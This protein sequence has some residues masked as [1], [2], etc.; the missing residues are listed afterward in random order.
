MS[1][2]MLPPYLFHFKEIWRLYWQFFETIS[3]YLRFPSKTVVIE[4]LARCL[5]QQDAVEE[6]NGTVYF[7][8]TS[9]QGNFV[10]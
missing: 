10:I 5:R 3:V 6:R 8:W 1:P 2:L 9:E 7:P 4:K